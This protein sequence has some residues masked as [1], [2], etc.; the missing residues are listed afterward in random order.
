MERAQFKT[1]R[2]DRPTAAQ[3]AEIVSRGF[4]SQFQR[5]WRQSQGLRPIFGISPGG[6]KNGFLGMQ[7]LK[8]G[9]ETRY[10]FYA[11]SR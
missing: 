9:Y 4:W 5:V 6:V 8:G 10:P 7:I 11:I 3:K 2:P 1:Q